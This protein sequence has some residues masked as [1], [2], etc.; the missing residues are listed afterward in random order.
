MTAFAP[1]VEPDE[2]QSMGRLAAEHGVPTYSHIRDLV[3]VT[4]DVRIDGALEIVQVAERTGAHMHF[5]HVHSVSAR[6]VDRVL[7]VVADARDR[8][9]GITTEAYPY[10]AGMTSIGAAFLT[11][12]GLRARQ[13]TVESLIYAPTGERLSSEARL[14]ELRASDPGG[15]VFVENLREDEPADRAMLLRALTFPDGLIA[16]D[17]M[18][19]LWPGD[20]VDAAVWPLPATVRTHPRTAGCFARGLRELAR[21]GSLSLMDFLRRSSLLPAQLMEKASPQ[22]ALKGRLQAGCDADLVLFDADAVTDQ[23]TYLESTRTS[24]GIQAVLVGGVPVVSGG[25]LVESALPGRPM[26]GRSS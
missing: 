8:G 21:G 11:P 25:Q 2:I 5:C 4:P 9:V 3:E 12:A 1:G 19:L 6:H 15:L 13:L 7:G 22:F 10:G 24:T 16:S 14:L 23:A 18:P 26:R 20:R 17:A